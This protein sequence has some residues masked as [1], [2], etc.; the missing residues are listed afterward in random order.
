[1]K[2]PASQKPWVTGMMNQVS[3]CVAL[4]GSKGHAATHSRGL[5]RFQ[6]YTASAAHAL[7]R[8]M[9]RSKV[10]PA[11]TGEAPRTSSRWPT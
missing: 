9:C 8:C 4:H 6:Q 10:A 2:S 3:S 5:E 7:C 1:V 11:V